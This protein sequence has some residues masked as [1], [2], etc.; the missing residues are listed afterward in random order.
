MANG[1]WGHCQHC[2]YFGSPARAPL[3][4]E[5]APCKHPELSRFQLIVFGASGCSGF[6][7]RPGTSAEVEAPVYS[8]SAP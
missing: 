2:K 4:A 1:N 5:E 3:G 6:E 8:A 7:L